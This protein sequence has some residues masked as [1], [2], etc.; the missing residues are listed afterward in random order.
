MKKYLL[1]VVGVMVLTVTAI[2]ASE[3]AKKAPSYA[4]RGLKPN[5]PYV[6][7]INGY[8]DHLSN[9]ILLKIGECWEPSGEGYIDFSSTSSDDGGCLKTNFNTSL[10]YGEYKVKLLL[11]DP[12]DNWKVVWHA[13]E[14]E[15]VIK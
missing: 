7:C 3:K 15:F 8:S 12:Y 14:V 9:K 4:L 1:I 11:K 13:D 10:P 6:L 5:H 2:N